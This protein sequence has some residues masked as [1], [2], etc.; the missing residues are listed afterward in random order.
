MVSERVGRLRRPDLKSALRAADTLPYTARARVRPRTPGRII[1]PMPTTDFSTLFELLPIGAYRS[2]PAGRQLRANAALVRL[3]GYADEAEM[4]AEV[5]DIGREWYVEATQ[6]AEFARRLE[7]D[8]HVVDFVSE[9]YRH[10]TRER[11]W[12]REN[13]H[14]VRDAGGAVLFFEG[15]VED[16]TAQRATQRALET[17]ERRFRAMTEKA[18]GLTIVCDAAGRITYAS[19]AAQRMLGLAPQALHG[20]DVF[21]RLHPDDAAAARAEFGN[22]I[23]KRNSGVETTARFAHAD[24]SWRH[25]AI[26]ANNCLA[27]DAVGGLV[28]N[29]RDVTERKCAEEALQRL[30]DHDVLTDLPN[31]R[32]MLSRIEQ[33]L[34][35]SL[36]RSRRL[37]AL[38]YLDLDDFKAI[39]DRQGHAAGDRLLRTVA[40]TLRG[41]VR[42][43]DT[44]ARFGGDE[45]VI[46]LADFES[47]RDP[48]T[49]QA[50]G[51]GEKI[52]A[53]LARPADAGG[54]ARTAS[55]GATLF[56]DRHE[57]VDDIVRRADSALYRAKGAGRNTLRLG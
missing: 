24:G 34:T 17:S 25:L 15:T 40:E 54:G 52:L 45:F 8:G 53:A 7:R 43:V 22:V 51:V 37:N 41:C 20:A 46:L 26:L 49:L 1:L 27:D 19:P 32:V 31:R 2:S 38:F 47:G 14:L 35:Y 12:V 10:K 13:A 23:D 56:G 33:A 57:A 55:L 50:Q 18:Q 39:N 42:A 29:L 11:I 4:L 21:E 28:L 36:T 44:V 30:A 5:G 48:A 16:I 3:N 6:R 9:V